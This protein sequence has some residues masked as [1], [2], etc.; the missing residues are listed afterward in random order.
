MPAPNRATALNPQWPASWLRPTQPRHRL[1]GYQAEAPS[2]SRAAPPERP[3]RQSSERNRGGRSTSSTSPTSA[4][5]KARRCCTPTKPDNILVD[6]P[7][8]RLIDWAWPTRGAGFIEPACLVV[9]LVHAGHTPAE[10]EALVAP[11]PAWIVAS[12]HAIDAF[13]AALS[14]MWAEVAAADPGSLWKQQMVAA[15]RAWRQHRH[16]DR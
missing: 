8:A 7:Q 15:A 1:V 2:R 16:A 6:G 11:L 12:S 3:A 5:C 10:A 4:C 9:R 14:S 13:A